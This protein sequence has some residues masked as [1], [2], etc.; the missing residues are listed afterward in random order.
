MSYIDKQQRYLEALNRA[1]NPRNLINIKTVL[2]A[3]AAR[4]I[5]GA[6]PGKNVLTFNAWK[7]K[8]R[9]VKKGEKALCMLGTFFERQVRDAGTGEVSRV[10]QMGRAA[11]FHISQTKSLGA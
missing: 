7:A 1:E 3:A 8:G 2:E 6:E 9:V 5:E 11:V 10:K 4:G